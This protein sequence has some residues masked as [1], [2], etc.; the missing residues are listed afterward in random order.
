MAL[1]EGEKAVCALSTSI[2]TGGRR[3]GRYSLGLDLPERTKEVRDLG[4][5]PAPASAKRGKPRDWGL[6]RLTLLALGLGIGTG[7]QVPCCFRDLIGLLHNPFFYG[8]ASVHYDA[9]RL[10]RAEPMGAVRA[11]GPRCRRPDRHFRGFEFRAGGKGTWRPRGDGRDILSRGDNPPDRRS[12]E[13]A[14]AST[15]CDWQR[16]FR[17]SGKPDVQIGSRWHRPSGGMVR[18]PAGQRITL[19]SAGAGAGIAATFNTP[20]GGV[21]FAIELMLPEV[22]VATFLP[23]AIATGAATFV[24]RWF[25]GPAPAFLVPPMEPLTADPSA[26][27][28]LVL[29]AGLGCG[30]RCG[31]GWVRARPAPF[32]GLVRQDPLAVP[33]TCAGDAVPRCPDARAV[34]HAWPVLRRWRRL[35]DDREHS[36]GRHATVLAV[37]IAVRVQTHRDL[38]K[39]RLR[40][41]PAASSRRLCSWAR[42]WVGASLHLCSLSAR[43]FTSASP[44]SP[45]SEWAPWSAAAKRRDDHAVTAAFEMTLDYGIVMPMILAVATSVGVRRMLSRENIY[46]LKLA[47][48][49]RTIPKAR[50]SN[51]FLVRHAREVM[52]SDVLIIPADVEFDGFLRQYAAEG[53]LRHVVVTNGNRIVGAIRVNTGIRRGLEGT[54]TGVLLADVANRQFTIADE[55]DVVS[56]VIERMWRKEA[57]MAIVVRARERGL[58]RADDVLGVITKEHVMETRS[59]KH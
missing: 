12:V 28:I 9:E 8:F 42:L 51:M 7:F 10:Y 17:G 5:R 31:R 4:L 58:P 15:V 11:P 52:D 35:C 38:L 46:T 24:G 6:A 47:R 55:D 57:F 27:L 19:V 3:R 37:G 21:M 29:Y 59:R 49:G 39:S 32:R 53:R 56:D 25:F 22:S 41:R 18:I 48:R 33:T 34:S 50:H 36:G 30:G 44:L 23:V 45:W 13:V 20:I 54:H 16:V 2:A 26:I 14:P 40:D 43:H 1:W